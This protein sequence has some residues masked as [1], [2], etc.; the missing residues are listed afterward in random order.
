MTYKKK[1]IT[2]R[3]VSPMPQNNKEIFCK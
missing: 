2:A 3:L 1:F